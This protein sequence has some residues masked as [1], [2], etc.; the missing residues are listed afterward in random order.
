MDLLTRLAGSFQGSKAESELGTAKPQLLLIFAG[1]VRR[2]GPDYK[3]L[4]IHSFILSFLLSRTNLRNHGD[5]SLLPLGK[6]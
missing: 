3:S 4:F 2:M 1:P 6:N 5:W